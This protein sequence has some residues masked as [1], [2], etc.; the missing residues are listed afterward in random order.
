MV[1][2][3][4]PS[5]VAYAA[6]DVPAAPSASTASMITISIAFVRNMRCEDATS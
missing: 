4:I 5:Q 6:T 1:I 2:A 3:G